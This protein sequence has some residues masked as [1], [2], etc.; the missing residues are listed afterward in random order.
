MPRTIL[1]LVWNAASG[2]CNDAPCQ[3]RDNTMQLPR[4]RLKLKLAFS[5]S[6]S[7]ASAMCLFKPETNQTTETISS[8]PSSQTESGG[9]RYL[10]VSWCFHVLLNVT[11]LQSKSVLVG[12]ASD[13]FPLI[14]ILRER[15]GRCTVEVNH[16]D[17]SSKSKYKSQ[18][19]QATL[20][21]ESSESSERLWSK[22]NKMNKVNT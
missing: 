16:K 1:L 19:S 9:L 8:S 22:V 17:H 12:S 20:I 18:K 13:P 14:F 21:S 11:E 2:H 4:K 15:E 7:T 10:S 5:D 6:S 3:Q